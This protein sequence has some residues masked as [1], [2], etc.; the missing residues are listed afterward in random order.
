VIEP[1]TVVIKAIHAFVAETAVLRPM[2]RD[3]NITQ[4]TSSILDDVLM[5]GPIEFRNGTFGLH[6]SDIRIGWVNEAC[7][8]VEYEDNSVHEPHDKIEGCPAL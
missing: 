5:L 4:V 2:M 8:K 3:R 6:F 1:S 7:S